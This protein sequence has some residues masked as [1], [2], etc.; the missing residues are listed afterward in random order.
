MCVD[1]LPARDQGICMVMQ[2]QEQCDAPTV[3]LNFRAKID[4]DMTTRSARFRN[5]KMAYL[6]N[7]A[8]R[9]PFDSNKKMPCHLFV[10]INR[11]PNNL[12][13]LTKPG[14][15]VQVNHEVKD[16]RWFLPRTRK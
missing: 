9:L 14:F 15:P 12:E 5:R 13:P 7:R 2:Y 1:P 10:G 16:N 6:V 4:R 11:L 8:V 3:S